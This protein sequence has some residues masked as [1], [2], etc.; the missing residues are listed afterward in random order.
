[1]VPLVS[2]TSKVASGEVVPIPTLPVLSTFILRLPEPSA[3]MM[4]LESA[5]DSPV[6]LAP[7]IVL[8]TPVTIPRPVLYPIAVLLPVPLFAVM[9]SS[10]RASTPAAVL[11]EPVVL[12][13][14]APTPL[15]VFQV[16]VVLERRA[17]W[18]IAILE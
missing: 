15:A 11:P 18:P 5:E 17:W 6:T 13:R 8:F 3:M 9:L 7:I 2:R 10:L 14:R 4:L 1:M 12:E 16:P